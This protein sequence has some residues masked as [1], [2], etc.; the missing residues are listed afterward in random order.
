[1]AV[2]DVDA[3]EEQD[4]PEKAGSGKSKDSKK[5]LLVIIVGLLVVLGGVFFAMRTMGS[6]GGGEEDEEFV[7]HTFQPLTVNIHKTLGTRHLSTTICVKLSN[8]KT[9]N[10]LV[11][12][13]PKFIDLLYRILGSKEFK[14]LD[15]HGQVVL[16]SEIRNAFNSQKELKAGEVRDVYFV[17]F[18]T[19]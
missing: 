16:R 2:E 14:Q 13:E 19:N 5:K 17:E 3:Q 11:E 8:Q 18:I 15:V 6:S 9:L 1:M 10:Q 4:Q 7:L 12:I